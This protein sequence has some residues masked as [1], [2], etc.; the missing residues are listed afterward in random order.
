[1]KEDRNKI[2][3]D[4]GEYLKRA[5]IPAWHF[6]LLE[7]MGYFEAPASKGHHLARRGGLAEHSAN[8]TR[9]LVELTDGMRVEW[10]RAQSP[11][12]VGMLHDLIKAKSYRL[13]LG[14]AEGEVRIDRVQPPLPGHGAASAMLAMSK[15]LGI[16]HGRKYKFSPDAIAQQCRDALALF[17]KPA[18]NENSGGDNFTAGKQECHYESEE[19]DGNK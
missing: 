11:Y 16:E 7:D 8:V 10:P 15:P 19:T 9:R 5:G 17:T 2:P 13:I 3:F 6:G 14:E 1:M 12:L 18:E 4:V